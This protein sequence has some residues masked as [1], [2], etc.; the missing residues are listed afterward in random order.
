MTKQ[1]EN[2]EIE[3]SPRNDNDLNELDNSI[4]LASNSSST[5]DTTMSR[6]SSGSTLCQVN[7]STKMPGLLRRT[8]SEEKTHKRLRVSI[9][10]S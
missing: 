7:N 4:L 2:P 9:N 8:A 1:C 6:D 10:A 3:S 5:V